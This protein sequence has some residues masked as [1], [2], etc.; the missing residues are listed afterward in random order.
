MGRN[1]VTKNLTIIKGDAL[2]PMEGYDFHVLE[3]IDSTALDGKE[4]ILRV[5][6]ARLFS[7]Y[8][9]MI[10]CTEIQVLERRR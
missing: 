10:S 8:D 4:S 6:I 1:T 3:S 2:S 5:L 7:E 9:K